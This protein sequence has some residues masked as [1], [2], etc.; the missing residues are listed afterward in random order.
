MN[1]YGMIDIAAREDTRPPIIA[2]RGGRQF[3][4]ADIAAREDTRPPI[5]AT[6]GGR[7]SS[8]AVPPEDKTLHNGR[9]AQSI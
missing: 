7:L 2:A 8:A 4:A 9:Y 6:R 1:L 3:S 5:F